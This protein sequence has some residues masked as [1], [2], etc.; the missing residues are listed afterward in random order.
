M[1]PR[2]PERRNRGFTL[3][4]VVVSLTLV[5]LIVAATLTA[6]RTLSDTQSRIE[7]TTDRLERM[8]LVSRFL[9]STLRQAVPV[10]PNPDAQGGT[11]AV[12]GQSDE[13]VWTAPLQGA[14]GAAGLH[15][16]RL[17]LDN[18]SSLAIQFAP[19]HLEPE[20]PDWGSLKPHILAENVREFSI[21]YR[22]PNDNQRG[23]GKW[24]PAW[25]EDR[26]QMPEAIRIR[27]RVGERYWPDL[28]V[29]P[30]QAGINNG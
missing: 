14:Q 6:M 24:L 11:S 4:E 27:I 28:V 1:A 13:M 15:Y 26:P 21:Q 10:T 19:R 17:Y 9:R 7:A 2:R 5:T 20:A 8:R 25:G 18:A 23:N 22:A 30:D 12:L 16:M 29:A 3:V